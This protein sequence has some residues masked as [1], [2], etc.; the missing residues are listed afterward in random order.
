MRPQRR[1]LTAAVVTLLLTLRAVGAPPEARPPSRTELE[2][3]R[4]E[5]RSLRKSLEKVRAAKQTAQQQLDAIDLEIS[6]MTRELALS[7]ANMQAVSVARTQAEAEAKRVATEI[8]REKR[9]ISSRLRQLYRLGGLSYLRLLILIDRDRNPLQAISMLTYLVSRDGREIKRF[10]ESK[11]TLAAT[12][13]TLSR[14]QARLT[15]AIAEVRERERALAVAH[16]EQEELLARLDVETKSSAQQLAELEEKAKRL[17]RLFTT[18][19]QTK[20]SS[21]AVG[22]AV[23]AFRGSFDWPLRGAIIEDFG[24]HRSERFATYTTSNGIRIAA[25]A[26]SEV[27]AVH[28]GTVLYSQWFKGYGNLIILDHGDRVFT[29]YGNTRLGLVRIGDRV[30]PGQSIATVNSS[31]SEPTHLY[32]E[33]RENNRPV[34]PRNWLRP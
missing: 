2:K 25:A 34:D 15:L 9:Q 7:V 30:Q 12:Q 29:L 26:N 8:E 14:E 28:G 20:Q 5:I 19:Y 17:E 21:P 4:A 1:L 24:R 33:I 32:F 10:Q 6:I 23:G 13:E 31:D 22:K 27:R 16:K 3:T 11:K 18:L